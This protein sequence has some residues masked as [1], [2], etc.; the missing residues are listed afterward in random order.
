[1]NPIEAGKP[2]H[3]DTKA[4]LIFKR[5][6]CNYLEVVGTNVGCDPTVFSFLIH[7]CS[8]RPTRAKPSCTPISRHSANIT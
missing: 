1:M 8:W 5:V 4:D 3:T 7:V 2:S 6:F